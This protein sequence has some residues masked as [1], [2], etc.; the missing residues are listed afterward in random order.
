MK[1]T[2]Y[3]PT[4]AVVKK[5]YIKSMNHYNEL[6]KKSIDDPE[7]F[8]GEIADQFYWETP[9]KN[10]FSYNFDLKKGPVEIKWLEGATTNICYNL[11]DKNVKNCLGDKI[12]FYW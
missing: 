6:Y 12:A 9:Y 8:W 11:L 1:K 10:F 7:A 4:A 3:E 2:V 5:A